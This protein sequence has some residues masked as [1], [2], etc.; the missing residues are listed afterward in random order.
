MS[1]K[2]TK[3][4]HANDKFY[5][6]TWTTKKGTWP[7]RPT[8]PTRPMWPMRP[9]P[10]IQGL[11]SKFLYT[12]LLNARLLIVKFFKTYWKRTCLKKFHFDRKLTTTYW[13]VRPLTSL[14]R[15]QQIN[16]SCF[17]KVNT[18]KFKIK[19]KYCPLRMYKISIKSIFHKLDSC[20]N[21]EYKSCN[22]NT[23]LLT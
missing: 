2:T 4:D 12:R 19:W 18:D 16:E 8:W 11:Y 3:S 13:F 5:R 9:M 22:S 20:K 6:L 1:Q 17:F 23:Y 15:G 10:W 7:I 21:N 14:T